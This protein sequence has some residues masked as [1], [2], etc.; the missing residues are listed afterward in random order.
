M[1]C[2]VVRESLGMLHREL[3]VTLTPVPRPYMWIFVVGWCSSGTTP[4]AGVRG[5]HEA[6]R[7]LPDEGQFLND[8]L[9]STM[10]S[11]SPGCRCS[12]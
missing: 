2:A 9:K 10:N 6:N 1:W 12:A 8:Q 11:D 3:K 7:A 4:L 5:T